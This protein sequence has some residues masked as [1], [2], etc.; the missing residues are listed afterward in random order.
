MYS[1]AASRRLVDALRLHAQHDNYVGAFERFFDPR[2]PPHVRRELFEFPRNPHRRPA[3]R[4]MRA[5]FAEQMNIRPCH[6][7]V[8]DV[9]ENR[10][11]QAVELARCDRESSA[12]RATPAWDA[13]ACRRPRSA[14]ESRGAWPRNLARPKTLWRITIPSGR[15][16]SSVRTVSISDSPFFRLDDSACRFIVS[17]PRR[18]AAVAKLMRVR[19][20]A[21]KNASAT[22]FPRKVA[23]FFSGCRW[24]SWNGASPDRE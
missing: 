1:S 9:A 19:V 7:A 20:E 4:N 17:A 22:V 6:A 12:R 23:N 13:R 18:D 21:S 2:R 3:Q 15:I 24:N 8:Q 11:V 14:P 16:A 5:E 10:D